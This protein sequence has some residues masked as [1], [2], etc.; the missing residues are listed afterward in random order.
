LLTADDW[1]LLG[2]Y[3]AYVNSQSLEDAWSTTYTRVTSAPKGWMGLADSPT[4]ALA[5]PEVP[6]PLCD[7]E[8]DDGNGD[9][10]DAADD[11]SGNAAVD[12]DLGEPGGLPY[13]DDIY[14]PPKRFCGEK[15]DCGRYPEGVISSGKCIGS[16]ICKTLRP[17]KAA[18]KKA[19]DEGLEGSASEE[20]SVWGV[21]LRTGTGE[22]A[23]DTYHFFMIAHIM[24]RPIRLILLPLWQAHIRDRPQIMLKFEVDGDDTL[25][26]NVLYKYLSDLGLDWEND[27]LQLL[28]IR[29][30]RVCAWD[31]LVIDDPAPILSSE[32]G[33]GDSVSIF[34]IW[35]ESIRPGSN[36]TAKANA[37]STQTDLASALASQMRAMDSLS[38]VVLA[39]GTKQI[40]IQNIGD[41][42]DEDEAD[43]NSETEWT[44]VLTDEW[45]KRAQIQRQITRKATQATVCDSLRDGL[46]LRWW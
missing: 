21:Q 26:F 43:S 36:R 3:P 41:K 44:K 27:H 22:G 11:G 15:G 9:A 7:Y 10:G 5:A 20:L 12:A 18:R 42:D 28:S 31:A 37:A 30:W 16:L 39:P 35:P 8:A 13:S 29:D 40:A 2:S 14:A 19:A 34:G 45:R 24:Y 33:D 46:A 32:G 23:R 38:K 6:L 25:A 1:N 4:L 17:S